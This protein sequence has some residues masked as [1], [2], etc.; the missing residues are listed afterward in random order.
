[1]HTVPLW[2]AK[3]PIGIMAEDRRGNPKKELAL[4]SMPNAIKRLVDVMIGID[5]N[6]RLE[7]WLISKANDDLQLITSDIEREKL[8]LEQRIHRLNSIRERLTEEDIREV[9]AGQT[10]LFDCFDIP[11]PMKYL[12]NRVE[13]I[14]NTEIHPAGTF[15]NLMGDDTCDDPLLAVT[16]QMMLIIAQELVGSGSKWVELDELF[17]PLLERGVIPEEC[18]E[19]LDHLLMTG[20]IHEVEDDCFIP[21]E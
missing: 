3:T 19:A 15:L 6:F 2:S 12:A 5:P 11:E 7:D 1:M 9:P 10:N 8:Q 17:A 14:E 18:D 16:S 20:Q 13:E 4:D 21:D